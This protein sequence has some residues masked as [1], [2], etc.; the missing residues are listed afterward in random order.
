MRS[1]ATKLTSMLGVT[2]VLALMAAEPAEARRGGSFGSRGARTYAAPPPTATAPR[3]T[4]PIQRS[5]TPDRPG[6][7]AQ[8]PA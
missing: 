8:A 4:A 3:A 6:A 2:L 1:A 5:M 7:T